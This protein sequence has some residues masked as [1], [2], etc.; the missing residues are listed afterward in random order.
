M[1]HLMTPTSAGIQNP[2]A[3]AWFVATAPHFSSTAA[4]YHA[5]AP[6]GCNAIFDPS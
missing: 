1:L 3:A 2:V 5:A 4:C 6:D